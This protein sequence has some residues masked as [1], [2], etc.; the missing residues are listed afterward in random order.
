MK[1]IIILGDDTDWQWHPLSTLTPFLAL[2][3]KKHISFDI[4]T[5]YGRLTPDRL[6]GYF[7]IVNYIDN[8][9]SRGSKAAEAALMD[10]LAAGN[11]MISI[12]NGIIINEASELQRLHGASFSHHDPFC[13][14]TFSLTEAGKKI[15]SD[16]GSF[17]FGDEPYEFI[18]IPETQKEVFLQYRRDGRIYPAGWRTQYG[19]GEIWYFCPGHTEK[20]MAEPAYLHL[21][22][23]CVG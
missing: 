8:W 4:C 5:D 18:D 22:A 19:K 9:K 1:K 17:S 3:E 12:H 23:E 7:V 11:K 10:W 14:L 16:P 13:G 6:A 2:L 21:L 20:A 15:F